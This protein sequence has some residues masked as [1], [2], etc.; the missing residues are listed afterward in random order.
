MKHLK[1]SLANTGQFNPFFLDYI[2]R[3]AALG[4]FY[5]NYPEPAAFEAQISS[6]HFST[7]HRQV[8]HQALRNQYEGIEHPP[9]Q[10]IDSLLQGHTYTVTTGHQLNIFTGP[11]YFIFKIITTIRLARQLQSLYPAH[12][13]VPVYWMASEDHDFTEINHFHLFGKTYT[14]EEEAPAGPVG[15]MGLEKLQELV[16]EIPE[17]PE[18]VKQAYTQADD[19]AG[20][21]RRL[22][23]SLF[24]K[25]GLVVLDG[26]D[27]SLKV[28]FRETMR[29]DLC[30]QVPHNLVQYTNQ[31]LEGLG[32]KAQVHPREI[33]LFY[34]EKGVRDRLER[35]Q[36]GH[37]ARVGT[38][39]QYTE[40][41]ILALLDKKPERFSPNVVLRPLY[42]ETILP[43]LAYIGGPAEMIYWLQLKA[44]FD[45]FQVA[46][47]ILFPRSFCLLVSEANRKKFEKLDV[48]FED[49]FKDEHALKMAYLEKVAGDVLNLDQELTDFSAI[50]DQITDKAL[51][52]DPSLEGYVRAEQQKM[53]KQ[54]EHIQKRLKK[55]QEQKE[56]TAL[57]Q[58][59]ALKARLFPGGSLQERHDNFLNFYLNNPE[60]LDEL[61]GCLDPFDFSMNLIVQ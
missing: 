17:L 60:W 29:A 33:N 37:F 24:G 18:F 28:L 51:Q 6:R 57:K 44:T 32:Y 14:W 5:Q 40:S 45:H 19:L 55:G 3:H 21:T 2:Q 7:H 48:P 4:S 43:N 59:L 16:K 12:R 1:I 22:V 36:T 30:D 34:I 23:H 20:A 58:L 13:F 10:E 47:P 15:L 54:L 39:I 31:Q 26:N 49:I 41:E 9:V 53:L 56:E 11:L 61:F 35:T 8:L 50:F 27:R 42:Q 38:D 46:F 52:I 25:Y